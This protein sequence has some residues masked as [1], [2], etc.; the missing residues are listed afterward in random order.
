MTEPHFHKFGRYKRTQFFKTKTIG[1][2]EFPPE[3][4][5]NQKS[6]VVSVCFC[7]ECLHDNWELGG[8]PMPEAFGCVSLLAPGSSD[9]LCGGSVFRCGDGSGCPGGWDRGGFKMV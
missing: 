7:S 8:N 5:S 4:P 1:I 9:R 3:N 6:T 2:R